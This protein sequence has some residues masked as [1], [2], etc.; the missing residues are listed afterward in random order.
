MNKYTPDE[1]KDVRVDKEARS[2]EPD[3]DISFEMEWA[4]TRGTYG[5]TDSDCYHPKCDN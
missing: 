5:N 1:A 3:L 2:K 4:E